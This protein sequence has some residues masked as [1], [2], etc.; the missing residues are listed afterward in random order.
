MIIM[1]LLLSCLRVLLI[2]GMIKMFGV[3]WFNYILLF[4][5]GFAC[6]VGATL[7]YV[8]RKFNILMSR[9]DF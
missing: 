4:V 9:S 7:Y 3:V 6:G 1:S 8:K 2:G 5:C